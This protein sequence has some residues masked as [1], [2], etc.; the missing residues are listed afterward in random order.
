VS[1][2]YLGLQ[3]DALALLKQ[4]GQPMTLR[5]VTDGAYD[6]ATGVV[7]RSEQDTTVTGAVFGINDERVNGST[8]LRGD[9]E[10]TISAKALAAP[11]ANGD[12][13]IVQGDRHQ[14]VS[15]A[16]LAPGGVAVIYKLQIRKAA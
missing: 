2:F 9:K 8:V 15:V 11:K 4:F 16:P 1:G 14:I 13:L 7:A 10:A 6:P 12:L 5:R 3:N